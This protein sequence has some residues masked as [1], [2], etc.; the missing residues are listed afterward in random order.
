MANSADHGRLG[1]TQMIDALLLTPVD[2]EKGT[3]RRV[4]FAGFH[5]SSI[6]P[7][8]GRETAYV[9][10]Q[11]CMKQ[12]LLPERYLEYDSEH[13]AYLIKLI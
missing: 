9:L 12:M 6:E 4:G 10:R 3:Y 11:W 8:G 7:E 2:E 5:S 13:H 1:H